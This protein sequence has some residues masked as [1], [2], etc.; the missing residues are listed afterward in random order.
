MFENRGE[1]TVDVFLI[2][3]RWV[4]QITHEKDVFLD[5]LAVALQAV[6]DRFLMRTK[7]ARYLRYI[8]LAAILNWLGL[9]HH[10]SWVEI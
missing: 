5:S 1:C 4:E 6:V 7:E 10:V 8:F 3:L 2:G 9:F